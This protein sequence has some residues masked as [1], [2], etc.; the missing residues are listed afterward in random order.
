VSVDL[1]TLLRELAPGERNPYGFVRRRWDWTAAA[2][3]PDLAPDEDLGLLARALANDPSAGTT[4]FTAST[5]AVDR[6]GD[7]VDQS[8]LTSDYKANPVVLDNHNSFRVVGKSI[9]TRVPKDTGNLELLV[10]WDLTNPDPLVQSVGHQHLNGFRSAGSV[11]F[12]AGKTT[13]RNKLDHGH[14]AYTEPTKI[15]TPWG[16]YETVGSF[17]QR[18]ALFEFSSASVPMNPQA[19]E[20]P[21][22]EGTKAALD[23]AD[24]L[25]E[26]EP[27]DRVGRASV[28]ARAA[29]PK[30]LA[31]ELVEL[32]RKDE[33]VRRIL[34]AHYEAGPARS[35]RAPT[36]K[37]AAKPAPLQLVGDGL[38]HLFPPTE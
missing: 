27:G 12:R 8:W 36:Q 26:L 2:A 1:E 6:A 31:D 23:L 20:R 37:P 34:L 11:G 16:S 33:R 10:Q 18:N 5:N 35:E 28:V 29:H 15:E 25:D 7:V 19:L 17:Y 9:D 3:V 22:R 14:Y 21:K 38:D 24:R 30:A 32:L 13:A 4:L